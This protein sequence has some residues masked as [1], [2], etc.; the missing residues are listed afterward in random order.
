MVAGRSGSAITAE[1]GS[2][3]MREEIDALRV[4]GARPGRTCWC[5]RAFS[6]LIIAGAAAELPLD[7]R[8]RFSAPMLTLWIYVDI[9]PVAFLAAAARCDRFLLVLERAHQGP[10]HGG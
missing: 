4:M 2:M 3:Q 1:L 6:A 8:E 10:V 9:P 5:C 7:A